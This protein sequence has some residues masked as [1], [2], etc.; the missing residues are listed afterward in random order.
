[1]IEVISEPGDRGST[2]V[3][4]RGID[5]G[6]PETCSW[7]WRPRAGAVI[8]LQHDG[9]VEDGVGAE[10]KEVAFDLVFSPVLSDNSSPRGTCLDPKG[11]HLGIEQE[12][13]PRAFESVETVHDREFRVDRAS[14]T[15]SGRTTLRPAPSIAP[16]GRRGNPV[17]AHRA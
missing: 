6:S 17:T 8:P 11:A 7:M 15:D 3:S 5:S 16:G 2:K 9:A 14:T 10:T 12:G 13:H 4:D 1:M